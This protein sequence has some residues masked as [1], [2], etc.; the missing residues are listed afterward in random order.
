LKPAHVNGRLLRTL[1][2]QKEGRNE[3]AAKAAREA[4]TLQPTNT[5]TLR[6]IG[7]GFLTSQHAA[8][9]LPVFQYVLQV[10]PKSAEALNRVAWILATHSD[11]RIRNGAEAVR[12]AQLACQVTSQVDP[13]SYNTLAAA[14]AEVGNFPA[15][16]AASEKSIQL[17]QG[18]G[19]NDRA[20]LFQGLLGLYRAGK[21][22]RE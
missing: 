2:L 11:A 14:Y 20:A 5:A 16:I 17:A 15:A 4:L 8:D 7:T 9:A 18:R 22:C 3:E 6:V 13:L 12:L 1:I 10:E 21:V 19:M